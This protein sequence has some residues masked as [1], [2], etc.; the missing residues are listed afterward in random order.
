M[1]HILYH[2]Y[3][4]SSLIVVYTTPITVCREQIDVCTCIDDAAACDIITSFLTAESL[5]FEVEVEV[6]GGEQ[7]ILGTVYN[8]RV[9]LGRRRLWVTVF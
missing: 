9:S 2:L 6:E 4:S 5:G 7:I 1:L 8:F 3:K